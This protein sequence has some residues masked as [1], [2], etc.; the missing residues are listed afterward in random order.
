MSNSVTKWFGDSF[1]KLDPLLQQLHRKGGC[2]NGDVTLAVENGFVGRRVAKALGLPLKSGIYTFSV[3]I[4]HIND[5]LHWSRTFEGTMKMKS[6]FEPHGLY[7]TGYW[8][9][10][11]G[12]VSLDMN[13]DIVDG[14]W[15]WKQRSI[16]VYGI[17]LP[18]WLF[19]KSKAY[20]YIE[21]G[22]YYFS[23][24]FSLPILGKL[25]GYSGKLSAG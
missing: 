1:E 7:P 5:Q 3:E 21:E 19:P 16:R 25:V 9:E 13:V 15:H 8:S 10:K 20:K 22:C 4:S 24:E 17:T 11:T 14:G 2:L 12:A 6:V 18:L 23:V